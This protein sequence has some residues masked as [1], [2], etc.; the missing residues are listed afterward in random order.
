MKCSKCEDAEL[1]PVTI[2]DIE[3]DRCNTCQ[4]IWFDKAE[5]PAL[6]KLD[7]EKLDGLLGG[8]KEE[9]DNKIG[10]CPRCDKRLLRV[11]A[12]S[13]REVILDT[14]AFCEGIWCD[15]GEFEALRAS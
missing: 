8:T 15:G 4:G 10:R 3:V 6:L 11:C 1:K 2:D 7:A 9:H 13:D 5:L 14:C 12:L